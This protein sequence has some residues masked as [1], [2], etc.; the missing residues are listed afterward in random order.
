MSEH[1]LFSP[2][3]ALEELDKHKQEIMEKTKLSQSE[4]EEFKSKLTKAVKFIPFS[5]Y[6]SFISE[7]FN[8]IPDN[9]K[10]IDS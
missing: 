7:A 8:L 10:D 4:F 3:F 5:D 9:A 6:S 1:D 2:E